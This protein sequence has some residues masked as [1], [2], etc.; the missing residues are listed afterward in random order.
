MK[1]WVAF[2]NAPSRSKVLSLGTEARDF[3]GGKATE[4]APVKFA[5]RRGRSTRTRPR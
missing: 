1:E 2:E 4:A 3:V 5:T